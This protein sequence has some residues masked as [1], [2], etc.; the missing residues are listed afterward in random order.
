MRKKIGL[1]GNDVLLFG[2]LLA[3]YF[4]IQLKF[5]GVTWFIT[6]EQDIMVLGKGIARGKLLYKDLTS[7]HMPI[8]Y[9]ISALFD[10]LGAVTVVQQRL[11]FYAFFSLCW[12]GIVLSYKKYIDQKILICY[13]IV[14]C[15]VIQNIVSGTQILSEH[16]AGIGA[17]LLLLEFLIFGKECK[18]GLK[19][20]VRISIA[21]LLTFGTI[22]VA[23]FPIFYIALG[24]LGQEICWKIDAKRQGLGTWMVYMVRK[25][26]ILFAIIAL[27]WIVLVI[28]Y[29]STNSFRIFIKSAYTLN[30]EVYPKYTGGFGGNIFETLFLTPLQMLGSYIFNTMNSIPSGISYGLVLNTLLVM[31]SILYIVMICRK[32]GMVTAIAIAM[33]V[34][35]F[36]VRGFF[37]YHSTAGTEVMAFMTTSVLVAGRMRFRRREG[38]SLLLGIEAM[39]VVFIASGYLNSINMTVDIS[40]VQGMSQQSEGSKIVHAIT[41]E[42]EGIWTVM[43]AN[44]I[45]MQSDR[46]PVGAAPTTPWTWEGLGKEQFSKL[47]KDMPRVALMDEEHVVW[48]YMLKDYAPKVIKFIKNHYTQFPNTACVYVRNDYY[49]EACEKVNGS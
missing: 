3:C 12:S 38:A 18:F 31:A 7:Q 1:L 24:V 8:S 42:S 25:Y 44:N 49:E 5:L 26:S 37:T 32:K 27:P 43:F 16:L 23:I 21:I 29:V 15:C 35:S 34:L 39:A 13:P 45:L 40:S 17:I 4:L 30:R 19:N 10:N 22:F 6:D 2:L 28:Y 14:H 48:G 9:Y 11:A 20:C 36:H 47:K 33:F 41:E 46:I